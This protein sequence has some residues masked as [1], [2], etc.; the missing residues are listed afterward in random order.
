VLLGA[1]LNSSIY[2][3]YP[4]VALEAIRVLLF[5]VFLLLVYSLIRIG[6]RVRQ[7]SKR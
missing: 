6:L 1:Q 2:D 3:R 7:L 5:C 4:S